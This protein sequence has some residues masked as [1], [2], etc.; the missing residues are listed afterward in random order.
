L[1]S[2]DASNPAG[3]AKKLTNQHSANKGNG[4]SDNRGDMMRQA[5]KNLSDERDEYVRALATDFNK[6]KLAER[7]ERLASLQAA[8]DIIRRD[9]GPSR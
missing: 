6:E 4:M 5:L 9:I 2:I 7:I 1:N 3:V 8:I